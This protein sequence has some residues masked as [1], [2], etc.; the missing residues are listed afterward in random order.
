MK[1][2]H[3]PEYDPAAGEP[4]EDIQPY[5]M[6]EYGGACGYCWQAYG[7]H[8][9]NLINEED[10]NEAHQVERIAEL[11][12]ALAHPLC[13][14]CHE[15]GECHCPEYVS[16][17]EKREAGLREAL[18]MLHDHVTSDPKIVHLINPWAIDKARAVLEVK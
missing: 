15:K 1:C 11:R 14:I 16:D 12:E 13:R 8:V 5:F 18:Q 10:V 4:E 2:K 17:L 7:R 3:H 6:G 9:C